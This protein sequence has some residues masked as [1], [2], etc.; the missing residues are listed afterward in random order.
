MF[1]FSPFHTHNLFLVQR[2]F[3]PTYTQLQAPQSVFRDGAKSKPNI[4]YVDEYNEGGTVIHRT[5]KKR[6]NFGV[7]FLISHRRA[8]YCVEM[9]L[10]S[11]NQMKVS[12]SYSNFFPFFPKAKRV[13][14]IVID[15]PRM[16][17]TAL[18]VPMVDKKI[19]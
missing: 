3:F 17:T 7:H 11:C 6:E 9:S 15:T 18:V 16:L 5:R 4:K 1:Y 8:F 12:S 14:S 13:Y 10:S 19:L 2:D